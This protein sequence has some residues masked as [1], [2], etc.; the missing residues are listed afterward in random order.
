M[1]TNYINRQME[2]RNTDEMEKHQINIE[3]WFLVG[4]NLKYHACG[5]VHSKISIQT[6]YFS[7]TVES[8][9]ILANLFCL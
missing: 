3:R 2:K 6:S 1:L 9:C 5:R 8:F 7:N 4:K